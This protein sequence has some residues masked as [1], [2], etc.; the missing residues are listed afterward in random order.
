MMKLK[1]LLA[2][3]FA[4]GCAISADFDDTS[5]VAKNLNSYLKGKD[6]YQ[7]RGW[8][9]H[10][11]AKY[12]W[13]LRTNEGKFPF[14]NSQVQN[15]YNDAK[16][17]KNKADEVQ[18][19]TWQKLGPFGNSPSFDNRYGI[20]R[21]NATR[22]H[23]TTGHLWVA[24]AGGGLWKSSNDGTNWIEVPFDNYLTVCVSDL[25]FS[26]QNPNVI[27]LATGDHDASISSGN[28]Y[29]SIG[30]LKSTD[31]GASWQTTPIT[32]QLRNNQL[33]GRVIVDPN[34]DNIVLAGTSEGIMRSED[35]G[36]T[37]KKV[38]N[39][40]NND[41][42]FAPD[43]SNIVY[44]ATVGRGGTSELLLSED[45]GKT[46][47]SIEKL[48]NCI[49][50]ALATTEAQ[51]GLV[52]AVGA[53]LDRSE[54]HSILKSVDYGKSYTLEY[55]KDDG[56]LNLLGW[57]LGTDDRGQGF[58]DLTIA[59]SQTDPRDVFV[60]GVNIWR[61]KDGGSNWSLLTHWRGDFNRPYVH[62]DQHDF[63]TTK[64]GFLYAS[65]DGGLDK[66][67]LS[68]NQ[69][70][71]LNGDFDITQ[72]YKIS[73]N[74]TNNLIMM[75][76][77]QDNGTTRYLSNAW[78]RVGGADG[79]DNAVDPTDTNRL[80]SS[81]YFGAISRSINGG[82]NF[83]L[84]LDT[85]MLR[86]D[87]GSTELGAWVAPF[88][89]DP[90]DSK[91]LYAGYNNV[92]KSDNYGAKG[93]WKKISSFGFSLQTTLRNL[94]VVPSDSKVIYA[95]T[96]GVIFKTTDGGVKW[97]QIFNSGN[98]IAHFSVDPINPN[99]LI[100]VKSG[101]GDNDKV[102]EIIDKTVKNLSGNL[103]N[104]PV[105]C[106]I[107]QKNSPDRI[108]IGSDIGVYFSDYGSAKWFRLEGAMP[109]VVISDL[110]INYATKK[111]YAGTFGRGVWATDLNE[112]NQPKVELLLEGTTQF[113]QGDSIVLSSKIDYP[114]Y[115]WSNG[116]TTKSIVVKTSGNYFLEIP[117]DEINSAK[118]NSVVVEVFN[119][120][121]LNV[122]NSKNLLLL[123]EGDS[124]RL[125]ANFGFRTY[126]WNTGVK[127]R[128]L[129]VSKT[130]IY[131]LTATNNSGCIERDTFNIFVLPKPQADS[132]KV[133]LDKKLVAPDADQYKWFYNNTIIENA[134]S[135]TYTPKVNGRYRCEYL[136]NGYCWGTTQ[137][138]NAVT[139]VELEPI[140]IVKIAPNPFNGIFSIEN[141]IGLEF[142]YS[143][144]DMNGR[145]VSN[146]NLIKRS[147]VD[148]S[149]Q[150]KGIYFLE[151]KHNDTLFR[152][153]LLNQ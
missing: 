106:V 76:G 93:S 114:S 138:I 14:T 28:P 88:L 3:T 139:S 19:V 104:L 127:S 6:I 149:N 42:E 100:V 39:L 113:C 75:T 89:I 91:T 58:F 21:I 128:N 132:I 105:N 52:M 62:A 94:A 101:F 137:E 46:F 134:T 121:A 53:T 16:S 122:T 110:E 141:I 71:N 133:E 30:L 20:G 82:N 115:K 81:I 130:G 112:F 12:F 148:I 102:F 45:N 67:T 90:N 125:S 152:F 118:S 40:F 50:I 7:E 59:I 109:D 87:Y 63:I 23:P 17:R 68:N 32:Y 8:K 143:V 24:T 129:D 31:G 86:K 15:A 38:N 151:L 116:A 11:R 61:S 107:V 126:E 48:T 18:A 131:I 124:T 47:R 69:W 79:M 55:S 80:Y 74:Q 98:S 37:W 66:L 153:K 145:V 65:H 43:N 64:S 83:E 97:E 22:I 36:A 5:S 60:G 85:S 135:Q 44:A 57:V 27:Y 78:R 49:R 96:F 84:V 108:Y 9:S 140:G 95:G 73:V 103:P 4:F 144:I 33:I 13:D 99:R 150:A 29:Y 120:T 10:A 111:L 70:K 54:F 56:G 25:A 77:A 117:Y 72:Y 1:I 51:K 142:E 35:A 146:G 41:L 26:R 123:C 119:R 34:N 92:W 2:I 136:K 147:E